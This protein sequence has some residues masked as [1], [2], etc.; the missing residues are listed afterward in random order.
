MRLI[1]SLVLIAP[2]LVAACRAP[3]RDASSSAATLPK[4]VEAV[5]LLGDTLRDFP[6]SASTRD[7]YEQ[8]LAQA[9]AAYERTP[10]NVDSI[11]WYGRRL[12]YLGRIRDAI[13]IY[14][15]GIALYP[16]NAWLYRHR[17]HRYISVR[18]FDHAIAD[19][20]RATQ[21]VDGKPDEI[22][23]DGQP[24]ARNTPIGTLHSNIAYH[25]GLARYLEGDFAGAVPVYQHEMAVATNDDRRVSTAHWLYMSLRRLGQDTAATRVLE[26]IS[27]QMDVV[28]NDAYHRLLLLYKGEMPLD[29]VLATDS[30]GEMSVADA[31]VAYGVGN[32]HLYN[33]RREEADRV[34]RRI[35]AGGQWGSFGYI[36][37]EA[38]LAR[39]RSR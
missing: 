12:A 5:S 11:I 6:L 8:Q 37:A 26:P 2:L 3:S 33:G 27:R 14:T 24:N 28:E 19:L 31:T 22:E 18:D 10:E 13:D 32:W 30:S 39:E 15:E 9:R 4:G 38:E 7:R 1:R 25:L 21:L 36:A 16:D 35:I 23:P 34:F 20:D 17:G 29:S